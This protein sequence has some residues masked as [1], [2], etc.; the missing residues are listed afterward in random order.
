MN[1][2]QVVWHKRIDRNVMR[3]AESGAGFLYGTCEDTRLLSGYVCVGLRTRTEK[4]FWEEGPQYRMWLVVKDLDEWRD[5]ELV[6]NGVDFGVVTWI[7]GL[8]HGLF[9]DDLGSET[10]DYVLSDVPSD[11][12]NEQMQEMGLE[13]L[14]DNMNIGQTNLSEEQ[15]RVKLI[16]DGIKTYKGKLSKKTGIPYLVEFRKHVG[17]HTINS[18]ELKEVWDNW[19]VL[20]ENNRSL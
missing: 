3:P 4:E 12:M 16:Y 8:T 7:H 6:V 19:C 9:T 13:T 1:E 10:V 14:D 11:W 15:L 20:Q 17:E 5:K 18:E 2:L